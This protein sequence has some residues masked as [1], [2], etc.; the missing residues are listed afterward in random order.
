MRVTSWNAGE[1]N[2]FFIDFV[3]YNSHALYNK[4]HKSLAHD[5]S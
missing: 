1:E 2:F 5:F 3:F 4:L